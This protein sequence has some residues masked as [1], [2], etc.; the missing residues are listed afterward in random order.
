MAKLDDL[1]SL[2]RFIGIEPFNLKHDWAHHISRPIRF[3][4]GDPSV[5]VSRLQTL[6]KSITLRRTKD[7]KIDSQSIMNIP[8]KFDDTV[9]L[10]LD[11]KERAL[12]DKMHSRAKTLLK[13]LESTGE[14]V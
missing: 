3:S 5:G 6:M 4:N 14:V 11:S 7:Q 13:G 9:L 8:P 1:Y 2:I 12:Y 10:E